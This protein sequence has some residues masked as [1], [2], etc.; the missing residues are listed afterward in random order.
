MNELEKNL[1]LATVPVLKEHGLELTKYFY[2]RMFTHNPELKNV[3]N[4]RNQQS[5]KQQTA[6]AMAVLAYAENIENPGVLMPILDRIGHKHVS[7]DIRPE[8]YTTV[9]R[10]LIASIAE[11]LGDAATQEIKE[12]WT[13]AYGELA[14]IMSGH[15]GVLYQNQ[16]NKENGWTG[17]KPFRIG[18]REIESD[19]IC[20]FYLYP[21]DSGKLPDYKP[22]QYISIKIY[23]PQLN[24]NQIRQYSLSDEPGKDYYRISVKK[25][26]SELINT[27]GMI[28]NYLH[29]SG[30]PGTI[31]ELSSPSGNFVLPEE[32]NFPLVFISGG[33]GATPFVSM[34]KYLSSKQHSHPICW[35]HACR[36]RDVHAFREFYQEMENSG[37]DFTGHIFYDKCSLE[38]IQA[39]VNEGH[40]NIG[41]LENTR[42]YKNTR[43]YI[44]GPAG[45][46]KKQ[47]GD[48]KKIG[49]DS[50]KIFFEEFG[51]QVLTPD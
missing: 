25:E 47:F 28:S 37:L 26:K 18:R 45:F 21:T 27:D 24:L 4:L 29:D 12:A 44:C 43:Y 20:S 17:W 31:V 46:I 15:E 16:V 14:A 30:Q 8:Q 41:S 38:D 48:L 11:V 51:P 22:G 49:V 9:G 42:Y 33:I 10:H 13:S 7:L 6:L 40:L 19:E 50:E 2:N 1:V 32:N 5:G 36:S 35:L 3:F 23:L 34:I 39:G